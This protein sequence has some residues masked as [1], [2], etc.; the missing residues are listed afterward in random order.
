M[1]FNT[2]L[3]TAQSSAGVFVPVIT[4]QRRTVLSDTIASQLRSIQVLVESGWF[5]F[6]SVLTLTGLMLQNLVND[7]QIFR[8]WG[9]VG[10]GVT[11][12]IGLIL[13][14]TV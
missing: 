13:F 12:V 10:G 7:Q 3:T 1:S 14:A 2:N 8:L 11:A 5:F 4:L 6:S 9:A